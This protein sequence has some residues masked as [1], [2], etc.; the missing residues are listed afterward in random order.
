MI[1][2]TS[3]GDR[4]AGGQT[5]P[6]AAAALFGA[7][8][9]ILLA[10]APASRAAPGPYE[11]ND[12]N[13]SA[14]GP[15]AGGQPYRAGVEATGDKDFFYF[16]VTSTDAHVTVAVANLGGGNKPSDID[17]KVLDANSTPLGG[18]NFI[19]GGEARMVAL[20]LEPGRY[21]VE[22]AAH[23]GFGDAY[24]L[25]PGGSPGAFGSYAQIAGRCAASQ[26]AASVAKRKLERAVAKLQRTTA[27]LRRS[28]YGT[29]A[30]R[31]S[32]RA[33]QRKAKL[34][35][36]AERHA[37]KEADESRRPWCFIAQ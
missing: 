25:T 1:A 28:R 4:G 7:I 27:R 20:D 34:R 9:L 33:E 35:V 19:G 10:V 13:L 24:E 21:F 15:L 11:P 36:R 22:V 16:Y 23:E 6:W 29:S 32:A 31:A 2:M 26:T 5:P 12:T 37:L 14:A 30:A 8:S 3:E 18:S 17:A